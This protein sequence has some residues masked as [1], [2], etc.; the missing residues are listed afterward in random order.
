MLETGYRKDL[1]QNSLQ[2]FL[3]ETQTLD[4]KDN[5]NTSSVIEIGHWGRE[6]DKEISKANE[7]FKKITEEHLTDFFLEADQVSL[8]SLKSRLENL[9]NTTN[10]NGAV[11]KT[12]MAVLAKNNYHQHLGK[13]NS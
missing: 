8:A 13:R 7:L 11:S 1:V 5:I 4:F 12:G 10:A 6:K 2:N 3:E 9:T